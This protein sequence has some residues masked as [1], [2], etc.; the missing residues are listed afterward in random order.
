M[1]VDYSNDSICGVINLELIALSKE[2]EGDYTET[3]DPFFATLA[4]FSGTI[5]TTT[6]T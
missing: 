2:G 1:G 6:E 4:P 5:T 3:P